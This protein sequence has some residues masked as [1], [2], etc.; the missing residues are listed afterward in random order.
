M[1]QGRR[2]QIGKGQLLSPYHH[3]HR[4]VFGACSALNE[5]EITYRTPPRPLTGYITSCVANLCLNCYHSTHI[6]V[7]LAILPCPWQTLSSLLSGSD[8]KVSIF[9]SSANHFCCLTN[10]EA[11]MAPPGLPTQSCPR[12]DDN[13]D[14]TATRSLPPLNFK[15]TAATNRLALTTGPTLPS[16]RHGHWPMECHATPR[17]KRLLANWRRAPLQWP[18]SLLSSAPPSPGGA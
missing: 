13:S 8:P 6:C 18:P 11:P 10:R 17:C 14:V 5:L 3:T 1:L 7:Q 12:G 16:V 9:F 2:V 4:C 15:F